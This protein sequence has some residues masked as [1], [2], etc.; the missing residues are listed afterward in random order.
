MSLLRRFL[1]QTSPH[2]QG[3]IDI[4]FWTHIFPAPPG[5]ER[6]LY[7][8]GCRTADA[9]LRAVIREIENFGVHEEHPK[10][11]STAQGGGMQQNFYGNVTIQSQAIATDNAIQSIGQ[12][13]DAIG[14][15][16]REIAEL[17]KQSGELKQREIKEGLAGIEGVAVEIQ[18]PEA[19]RDWRKVLD[20]GQVVLTIADKATDL[21]HKL[22]P[23]LPAILTLM[24][25]AKHWVK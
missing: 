16:L 15:N 20:S 22:G 10:K 21:V 2:L 7:V 24:E 19:K 8:D 12:M 5:H 9:S 23:Y 11:Q 4:G 3:F 18:K 14:S 13:G 1:S 6:K 17:F 25:N